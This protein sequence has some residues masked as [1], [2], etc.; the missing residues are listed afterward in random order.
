ML[1]LLRVSERRLFV[2]LRLVKLIRDDEEPTESSLPTKGALI[3]ERNAYTTLKVKPIA[4]LPTN[5]RRFFTLSS[6]NPSP[7][8]GP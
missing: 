7:I 1:L 6:T 4:G 3:E 8:D 5:I 2:L